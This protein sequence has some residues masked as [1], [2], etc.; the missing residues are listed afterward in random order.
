MSDRNILLVHFNKLSQQYSFVLHST[1]KFRSELHHFL[2]VLECYT[3]VYRYSIWDYS[4]KEVDYTYL[5]KTISLLTSYI[6]SFSF[7]L[8]SLRHSILNICAQHGFPCPNLDVINDVNHVD[9]KHQ[10]SMKLHLPILSQSAPYQKRKH[11]R[12][13][14][15]LHSILFCL[16]FFV[17]FLMLVI[18]LKNLEFIFFVSINLFQ[19]YRIFL[20]RFYSSIYY[21]NKI[22]FII[23]FIFLLLVRILF[24]FIISI[25][26]IT[27]L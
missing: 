1:L 6:L 27:S 21:V 11:F 12:K 4:N 16:S 22:V 5:I 24:P 20:F 23:D 3:P 9:H 7:T 13:K 17:I 26:L 19:Y 25:F 10:E 15:Q 18:E 2:S 14:R 8:A